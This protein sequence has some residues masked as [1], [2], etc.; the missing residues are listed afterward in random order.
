MWNEEF[1]QF[2]GLF[3]LCDNNRIREWLMMIVKLLNQEREIEK[4]G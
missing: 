1:A 3:H 4:E 2:A